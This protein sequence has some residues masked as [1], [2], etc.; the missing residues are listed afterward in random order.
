MYPNPERQICDVFTSMWTLAH[1][2]E[3][4]L[5]SKFQFFSDVRIAN[6]LFHYV[7]CHSFYC[8]FCCVEMP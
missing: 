2:T 5:Y 3:I 1:V 8:F 7:N 4:L 6:I